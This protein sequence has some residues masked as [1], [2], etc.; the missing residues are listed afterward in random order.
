MY[1][2]F[3]FKSRSAHRLMLT[4]RMLYK[5]DKRNQQG[6]IYELTKRKH[7]KEM[8]KSIKE[9]TI[10]V[11]E[12]RTVIS[13]T[14]MKIDV[15]LF[16]ALQ[17]IRQGI[18]IYNHRLTAYNS[19]RHSGKCSIMDYTN[20]SLVVPVFVFV[21]FCFCFCFFF[22]NAKSLRDYLHFDKTYHFI[23]PC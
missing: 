6:L 15:T 7:G 10:S 12:S 18:H 4:L 22:C 23:N 13:S 3:L 20:K 9:A 5:H 17:N 19:A 1:S 14:S 2:T 16:I 11:K 21:L 8:C